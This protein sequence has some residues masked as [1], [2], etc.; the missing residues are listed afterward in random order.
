MYITMRSFLSKGISHVPPVFT[1]TPIKHKQ[2]ID[3]L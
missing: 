2:A 3:V 1:F